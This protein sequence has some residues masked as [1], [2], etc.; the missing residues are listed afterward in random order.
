LK[1]K[2]VKNELGRKYR[3]RI[4]DIDG[5]LS[6]VLTYNTQTG[7]PIFISQRDIREFQLAKGAI[8][9]GIDILLKA[10]GAKAEDIREVLLAGAFGN[11]LN[12]KSAYR[13]NLIPEQLEDKTRGI[14]NAAGV[15]AKCGL[16]SEK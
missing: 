9:A 3:D 15:G 2:E 5:V 8:A 1:P 11:Y 6:F 16:L 14:G 7:K 12:Y 4:I 10:Y 13:V